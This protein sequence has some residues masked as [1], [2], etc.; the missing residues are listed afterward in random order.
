MT[1]E[2]IQNSDWVH[3]EYMNARIENTIANGKIRI[4]SFDTVEY[5]FAESGPIS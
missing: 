1:F 4:Y 5:V 3:F 2:R